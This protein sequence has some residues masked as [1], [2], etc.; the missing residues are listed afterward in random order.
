MGKGAHSAAS[1]FLSASRRPS[2]PSPVRQDSNR[3][4][5]RSGWGSE[6]P[7]GSRSDLFS[8]SRRRWLFP[9]GFPAPAGMTTV[10]RKLQLAGEARS[11]ASNTARM[12]SACSSLG[13]RENGGSTPELHNEV[14]WA[15]TG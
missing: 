12:R 7:A 8:T 14:R 1:S 9:L 4:E 2:S 6:H 15:A 10:S 13:R 5:G 3:W 11:E